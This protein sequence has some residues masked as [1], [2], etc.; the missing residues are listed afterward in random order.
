MAV[1]AF[2]VLNVSPMIF[3]M[4]PPRPGMFP[5]PPYS[6][7]VTRWVAGLFEPNEL[8]CSDLPWSMAWD[9]DRRTIWLPMTIDEFYQISDFVAPNS[10][11][12]ALLTPYMLDTKRQSEVV[13]GEYKGWASVLQ[14][15][16][17]ADFPLKAFM[18]PTP[19]HIL[20]ADRARWAKKPT[21]EAPPGTAQPL[22][23]SGTNAPAPSAD[24]TNQLA[25]PSTDGAKPAP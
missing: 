11:Q 13:K 10:V 22:E 8:G 24:S 17:R 4:L 5:Y 12:F 16:L 23:T 6:P 9:G 15:Q 14:G 3:T 25:V 21:E 19:D 2:V 1:G 20:L 7:P 18:A